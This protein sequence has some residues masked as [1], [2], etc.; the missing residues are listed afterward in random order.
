MFLRCLALGFGALGAVGA[1]AQQFNSDNQWTAPHGVGTFVATAGE[2]YSTVLGVAALVEDWEFNIGITHYHGG[3]ERLTDSHNTGTLYV[4]HR[5]KENEKQNG[6][7]AYTF[8]TGIDPSHLEAGAVTDTFK[9]W[10]GNFIYSVPFRDGRIQLDLVPGLLVN[11]DK[12]RDNK[13]T[14]GMTYSSRAAFY[15][16]IP[17]SAIVAEVFG[18]TGEAYSAPGYRVGVRWE[19]PNLIV[20]ASYSDAFN[21]SGG[22]GF[23]IGVMYLSKPRFCFGGC[24]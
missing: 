24:H 21:G 16:I 11:R 19:R 2:E 12:T 22:A 7:L 3:S 13:A 9:S 10:W 6:G 4:K 8:G 5:I 17:K 20:A 23:E 18:T 15:G 14:S 1:H